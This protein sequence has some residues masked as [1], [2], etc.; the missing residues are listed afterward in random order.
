MG[1]CKRLNAEEM[2]N[3][4]K[5]PVAAK[6]KSGNTRNTNDLITAKLGALQFYQLAIA[7]PKPPNGSFD[8]TAADRGDKLFEGKAK[9]A[10]CHVPP[11]Y[12][13]PGWNMHT[14]KEI[15]IDDFQAG[16]S[17][18]DAYRTTPLSGLW[19]HIKGGFYH[20]GRFATLKDVIDHYDT[21]LKLGL[22]DQEKQDLIQYLMSL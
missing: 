14:A 11:L 21:F 2:N 3:A 6:A 15:G 20:D 19:S 16:R 8:K 12:T 5:Y 4:S 1:A 13:E 9:C 18:D 10:T 22:T 17:P 7:A